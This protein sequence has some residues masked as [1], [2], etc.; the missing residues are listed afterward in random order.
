M[1]TCS[2]SENL[3]T[4]RLF[5][6][7]SES[8]AQALDAHLAQCDACRNLADELSGTLRAM[9]QRRRPDPGPEFWDGYWDRLSARMNDKPTESKPTAKVLAF[10]GWPLRALA[11][12]AVLVLGIFLGRMTATR[13]PHSVPSDGG[14]SPTMQMASLNQRTSDYLQRSKMLI[15]GLINFDTEGDTYTL[16]LPKQRTISQELLSEA[17]LLKS[18][19]QDQP[20][21]RLSQLVTDLEVIL[22]QIANL[23]SEHDLDAIEM[24]K[25]GVDRRG[26][27]LKI[28]LEEMKQTSS[29]APHKEFPPRAES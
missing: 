5:G 7:L 2:Q 3:I 14:Q 29:P 23:E 21:A 25:S 22:M 17:T 8:D 28:N 18:E 11:S 1:L 26:V 9:D 10:Q 13:Q 15:L 12:A 4:E 16:N 6:T 24:V 19:L 27:L 20:Q